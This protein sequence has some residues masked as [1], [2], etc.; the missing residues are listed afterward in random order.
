[1][2][3]PRHRRPSS[4]E[5]KSDVEK[6]LLAKGE[7]APIV[8]RTPRQIIADK[9][10]LMRHELP[11]LYGFPMYRWARAYFESRAKMNLLCSGNQ[12]GK[13]TTL[14]QKNIEWACNKKLWP[15]LWKTEPRQF[16]YF[17]PSAEV[18]TIEF[19]KKWLPDF[20]PRGSMKLDPQYG[21]SAEYSNSAI[22]ALHFNSGVT[23]FFKSY[24][25]RS[26]NL[27][28]STVH[29]VSCD[30]E[31]PPEYVDECLARIAATDGYFNTV[32]TATQGYP[33]WYR[34]MECIGTPDEAFKDAFKLCVS[35]YDCQVYED[36]TPG[37]WTLER[38]KQREAM[39]SSDM[40]IRRRVLGRFVKDDGKR[41][42]SFDPERLH[43]PPT[44]VSKDWRCYIGVDIGSGGGIH[45]SSGAIAVIAVNPLMS[46]ARVIHTW[47]GDYEETTAADILR[48][49]QEI[50]KTLPVPVQQ[51]CYDH[52]S[53][54]FGVIAARNGENFVMADK[55]TA[56]GDQT[57]NTLFGSGALTV[58][59]AYD[60]QKLVTELM[61]VSSD[62][63]KAR[64]KRYKNDL[65][66][67]L[68]Y[69]AML[70]PWDFTAITARQIAAKGLEPFVKV[71]GSDEYG[72]VPPKDPKKY[73]AWEIRQRRGEMEPRKE[74]NWDEFY[75]EIDEWN[76]LMDGEL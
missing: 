56:T 35:L 43:K 50:V 76:S 53:R 64:K 66:D 32:F 52:Q 11:H 13:S 8:P 72:E 14:I 33:L 67:A 37:V 47:R 24:G 46:E 17:Y 58:D 71:D 31:M 74:G 1:M 49:Y 15:T 16:W 40:E 20:L 21:W 39:C 70:V 19:T 9:I 2:N 62:D 38:I 65:S 55:K 45:R 12:V 5:A 69:A 73:L 42:Q 48:K 30:E 63:I 57:I 23:I 26:I 4:Q 36:G 68:R 27:Q 51:A 22:E 59:I 41:Y 44:P 7:L 25:Q 28:T 61:S 54:E 75:Q 34:A 10:A 6:T 3:R 60:S 18:A 29:V